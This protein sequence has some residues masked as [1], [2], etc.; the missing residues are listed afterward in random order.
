MFWAI[1]HVVRKQFRPTNKKFSKNILHNISDVLNFVN[2][3]QMLLK[4][5]LFLYIRVSLRLF[6]RQCH[7]KK[8]IF[9]GHD[10]FHVLSFNWLHK[11]QDTCNIW[12]LLFLSRPQWRQVSFSS[13]QKVAYC[14]RE[15]RSLFWSG[16]TTG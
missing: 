9:L 8:Q 14:H 10:A 5:Q 16:D 3:T 11:F 13:R 12:K 4:W 15:R 7:S 1:N 6:D 2:W